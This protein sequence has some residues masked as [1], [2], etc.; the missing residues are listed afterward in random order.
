MTSTNGIEGLSMAALLLLIV[1]VVLVGMW[2]RRKAAREAA[3][4]LAERDALTAALAAAQQESAAAAEERARLEVNAAAAAAA[5]NTLQ[6][7]LQQLTT[8]ISERLLQQQSASFAQTTEAL[9]QRAAAEVRTMRDVLER[10]T[11]ERAAAQLTPIN[12]ALTRLEGM[13][14]ASREGGALTAGRVESLLQTVTEEQRRHWQETRQLRSA[15][16]SPQ[17]RGQFGEYTLLRALED[18]GLR[19]GV[20]FEV[21]AADHDE[22]GGFRPD[23]LVRLPGDRLIIVDSKAPLEHLLQVY[24]SDDA[25][26]QRSS[27]EQHARALRR[28][29]DQLAAKAYPRR[30]QASARLAQAANVWTCVL[31]YVPSETV[32]DVA[33]RGDPTLLQHA[34]ER[35]VCLASPTTL[36]AV[37]NTVEQ[38]WRQ[39]QLSREAEQIVQAGTQL[40]ERLGQLLRHT[41]ALGTSLTRSVDAYNALVGSMESRLIPSART[42]R[43]TGLRLAE[44]AHAP[45]VITGPLRVFGHRAQELATSADAPHPQHQED[46]QE[47]AA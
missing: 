9:E 19:A 44:P 37:L 4:A 31:L 36:L 35:R 30:V 15:F 38:V 45:T 32:L 34:S 2:Y 8:D 14:A 41:T 23:V 1:P 7:A 40:Y 3:G 24:A 16:Q 28:H 29:I 42:L 43:S 25:E 22:G 26:E 47:R 6:V 39:D 46:P 5:T 33:F 17:V 27:V 13:L 21:Q 10:A 11:D 12:A 20:H 18:A